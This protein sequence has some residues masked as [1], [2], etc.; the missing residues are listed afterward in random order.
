MSHDVLCPYTR[1]KDKIHNEK[2]SDCILCEV[3]SRSVQQD[4]VAM[5]RIGGNSDFK[6][7]VG[8]ITWDWTAVNALVRQM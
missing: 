4:F 7:I 3:R 1:T 8:D 6:P 2:A 5:T